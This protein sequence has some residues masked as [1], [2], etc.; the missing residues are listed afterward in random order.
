MELSQRVYRIFIDSRATY[1]SRRVH[2][3]LRQE[4]VRV[5][6][7]TVERIMRQKGLAPNRKRSNKSTTDSKHKLPIAENKLNRQFKRLQAND[8]WVS[9]ITYIETHE[10]WL[11]LAVFL[12]LYSRKIVGWSMAKCM[13]AELVVCAYQ[14]GLQNRRTVPKLVHSDRGSQYA[15]NEFTEILKG[16]CP[17]SMSRKADCWDNAVSESFWKTLKTE[18]VYRQVFKTREEAELAIFEFIEIFY[19]KRRLHSALGYLSPE[20]FELQT[21][22]AA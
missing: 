2:A 15:S 3:K 6:R 9:D 13:T 22:K 5:S 8:V 17:Q 16:V 21:Q 7:T 10:G 18:L 1:G 20:Q 12:D 19:N 4:G 11:Y 14:M